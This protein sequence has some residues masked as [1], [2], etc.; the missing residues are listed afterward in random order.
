MEIH[1][2]GG[3]YTL[4]K[5]LSAIDKLSKGIYDYI[6][7]ITGIA[8]TLLIMA[9]ALMRYVFHIDFYGSEEI[10]MIV[11]FWLFFVGSISAARS[12]THLNA[13]MISVFTNNQK[14]ISIAALT[15]DILSLI[16]C[17]LA[18]YWCYGYW[19]WTF[20]LSPKTSVFKLPYYIQQFPL[21]LSFLIWGIYLIRDCCNSIL[22]VKS[23]DKVK[24]KIVDGGSSL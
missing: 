14:A 21:C 10:I 3:D 17:C 23:A 16:I 9:G 11:G 6:M 7:M 18:I 5:V 4:L 2:Q 24:N 20:K 13:N 8:V 19:N 22:A 15:K 12:K 1:F